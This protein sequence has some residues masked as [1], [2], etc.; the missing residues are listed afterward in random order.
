MMPT[1]TQIRAMSLMAATPGDPLS[2]IAARS[3]DR[4]CSPSVAVR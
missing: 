3:G 1:M 2:T 4:A